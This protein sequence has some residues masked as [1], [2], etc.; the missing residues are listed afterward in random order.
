MSTMPLVDKSNSV[1]M[2]GDIAYL[3]IDGIIPG[4]RNIY[5]RFDLELSSPRKKVSRL[6][7]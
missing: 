6:G 7:L 2:F 4:L 1:R 3:N 5:Y